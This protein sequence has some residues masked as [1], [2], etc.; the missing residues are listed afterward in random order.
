MIPD[1]AKVALTLIA[2]RWHMTAMLIVLV[3][4]VSCENP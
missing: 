3:E 4:E 2:R 1:A